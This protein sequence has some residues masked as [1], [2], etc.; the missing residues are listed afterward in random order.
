MRTSVSGT[1]EAE[2]EDPWAQEFKSSLDNI[3]RPWLKKRKD[4]PTVIYSYDKYIL[5]IWYVFVPGKALDNK[6]ML[7]LA[8]MSIIEY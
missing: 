2:M 5:N 7:W 4:E 3:A 6:N 1:R 8:K